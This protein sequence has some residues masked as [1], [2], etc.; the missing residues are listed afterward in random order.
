M[1]TV[2]VKLNQTIFDLAAEQYGT[3]EA[4]GEIL[5]N[6]PHLTNDKTA[7]T[8]LGIDYL[9]DT[10]FY[11]DAP[12]E[13]GFKLQ[14]DTDSKLIKTSITKEINIDVTTYDNENN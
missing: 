13:V 7:L 9:S 2:I 12:V 8:A 14:I 5:K 6:N 10:E 3:S 4:V 11:I 1:Q